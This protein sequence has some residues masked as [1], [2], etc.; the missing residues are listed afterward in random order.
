M[1]LISLYG[2]LL[3]ELLSTEDIDEDISGGV[4]ASNLVISAA[5][6]GLAIEGI[7]LLLHYLNPYCFNNRYNIFNVMVIYNHI[8][9]YSYS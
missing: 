3:S 6:V 9:Y 4:L 7:M 1:G 2:T 5:P 8:I